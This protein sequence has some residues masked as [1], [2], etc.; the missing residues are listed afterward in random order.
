MASR[1]VGRSGSGQNIKDPG[2][3]KLACFGISVPSVL[4]TTDR[5]A[6]FW[7]SG[8]RIPRDIDLSSCTIFEVWMTGLVTGK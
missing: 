5:L 6:N 8:L 4:V 7:A 2:P 1:Q 3:A